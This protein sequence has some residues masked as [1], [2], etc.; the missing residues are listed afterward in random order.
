MH[1]IKSHS[2]DSREI[3]MDDDDNFVIIMR[4][5]FLLHLLCK[6]FE[7]KYFQCCYLKIYIVVNE[8][9]IYDHSEISFKKYSASSLDVVIRIMLYMLI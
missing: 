3:K 5:Y 6:N 1:L 2:H 7:I 9:K 4:C 8:K